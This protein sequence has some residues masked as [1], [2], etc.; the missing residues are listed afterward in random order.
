MNDNPYAPPQSD[1]SG[2]AEPVAFR[3]LSRSGVASLLLASFASVW[4]LIAVAHVRPD[5][6]NRVPV[7]TSEGPFAG[8]IATITWT[9]LVVSF[10]AGI[11]AMIAMQEA[12]RPLLLAIFAFALAAA[13][14][15][16][17]FYCWVAIYED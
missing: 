5:R 17:T 9:A 2:D 16:I 1:A 13:N 14:F 3:T 7:V 11:L 15:G 10:V 6:T 8:Y 12:G 4:L